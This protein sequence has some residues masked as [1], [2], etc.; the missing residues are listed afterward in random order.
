[1]KYLASLILFCSL[2]CYAGIFGPSDYDECVLDGVKAAQ[3]QT[4]VA[5][6]H[7][8]C[9]NKFPK[10]PSPF[11]KDGVCEVYWDG[12]KMVGGKK[13]KESGYATF[14]IEGSN[15]E[16]FKLGIPKS[17]DDK[18]KLSG[19]AYEKNVLEFAESK[20]QEMKAICQ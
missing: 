9:R 12:W 3:T 10:Q 18:L 1:M 6:V 17:L 2:T 8:A 5:S 20:E 13:L 14:T 7:K 16:R 19:G 15:A 4:A 11:V